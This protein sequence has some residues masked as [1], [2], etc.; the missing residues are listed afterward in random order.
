MTAPLV[1]PLEGLEPSQLSVAGGKAVN[2]GELIRAEL[3][4]PPGVCVTT[5][6]YAQAADALD[7]DASIT[8]LEAT[9]AEQLATQAEALRHTIEAAP[10][11]PEIA[12]AIEQA[13]AALGANEKL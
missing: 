2:L 10:V 11:P 8:A 5:E 9:N 3:P 1:V 12:Q 4:V 7:L 13:V 6:A